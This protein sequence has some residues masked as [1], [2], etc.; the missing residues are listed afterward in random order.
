[1]LPVNDIAN[2]TDG[3]GITCLENFYCLPEKVMNEVL[4]NNWES[5][6]GLNIDKATGVNTHLR[7][8]YVYVIQL[9][10]SQSLSWTDAAV[11]MLHMVAMMDPSAW[12]SVLHRSTPSS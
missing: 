12:L 8:I 1:M 5:R 2:K 9:V 3:T 7:F 11:K 4:G 6:T 10:Q